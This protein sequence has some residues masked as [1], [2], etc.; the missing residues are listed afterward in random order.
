MNNSGSN[1]KETF[2]ARIKTKELNLICFQLDL[3]KY[4]VT[5]VNII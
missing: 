2:F 5:L 3:Q 4:I 1:V